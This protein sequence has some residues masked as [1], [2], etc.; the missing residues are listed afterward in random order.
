MAGIYQQSRFKAEMKRVQTN[1]KTLRA[2]R[3][4]AP[5]SD[6]SVAK[7]NQVDGF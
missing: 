2:L 6:H 5:A 7:A 3:M 4:E 1:R